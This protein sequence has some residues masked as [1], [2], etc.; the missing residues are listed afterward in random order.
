MQQVIRPFMLRRTKV[1]VAKELPAKTVA[2]IMCGLSAW[3]EALYSQI[4]ARVSLCFLI[5]HCF[6]YSFVEFSGFAILI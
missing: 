1:E 6:L 5:S 4:S 3:Q 2:H